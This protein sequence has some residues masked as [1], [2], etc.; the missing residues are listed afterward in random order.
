MKRRNTYNPKR[1]IRDTVD[2]ILL[3]DLLKRVSYKGN[4]EHKQN[5]GD[6]GLIPPALPRP[7]KTLCDTVSLFSR[8][9]AIQL[10]HCGIQKGFISVQMRGDYPQNVWAVSAE[11]FAFE[12]QLDNSELGSYHGYPLPESDPFRDYLLKRWSDGV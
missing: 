9:V 8:K 2:A 6:F 3:A 11:G 4:P 10:L 5:P 7:D 1:Q 12:A